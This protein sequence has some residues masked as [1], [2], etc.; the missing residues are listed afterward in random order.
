MGRRCS[1]NARSN[2]NQK[3]STYPTILFL[4]TAL[5]FES[6]RGRF[7]DPFGPAHEDL[8]YCT[9]KATVPTVA[10]TE[11]DVPVTVIV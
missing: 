3:R 4:N 10:L 7:G 9:V 2:L 5:P 8:C 1:S 11:P 6:K